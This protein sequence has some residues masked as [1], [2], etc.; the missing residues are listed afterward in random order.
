MLAPQLLA[1]NNYY[2]LHINSLICGSNVV[3]IVSTEF[4]AFSATLCKIPPDETA[5]FTHPINPDPGI[6]LFE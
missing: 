2:K 1:L 3:I 4:F 5:P 6:K